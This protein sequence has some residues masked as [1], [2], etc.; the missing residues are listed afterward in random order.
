MLLRSFVLCVSLFASGFAFAEQTEVLDLA[1]P[2]VQRTVLAGEPIRLL[3]RNR[4]PNKRYTVKTIRREIPIPPFEVPEGM[5]RSGAGLCGQLPGVFEQSVET[6]TSEE[7]LTAKI[8]EIRAAA[9]ANS[10]SDAEKAAMEVAIASTTQTVE[11][12]FTLEQGEELFVVVEREDRKWEFAVSTGARG[13]WRVFYGFNFLPNQDQNYFSAQDPDNPG[14]FIITQQAD[15]E[16]FD[17]AP[18]VFFTWRPASQLRKDWGHGLAVG[19]GFDL[20][21]PIVF[22]GYAFT[23]NENVSLNIG[24]VF[25][26]QNRLNGRYNEGDVIMENLGNEQ[27][28]EETYDINFYLGVGFRF[29]DNPFNSSENK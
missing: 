18:S 8:T 4:L 9:V 28:T 11:Q 23:Y 17:F 16:D 26:K 1:N 5:T 27:L 3:I 13:A 2:V 24:A 14:S 21:N 7:Q 22:G 15:R 25:H 20:N 10:C 29:S 6:L 12:V 19:L